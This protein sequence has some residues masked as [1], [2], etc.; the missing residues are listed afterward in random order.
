MIYFICIGYL[1]GSMPSGYL[2][3][4]WFAGIDIRAKGSGSTGATNVLREVGKAA[5]IGVLIVD[6]AKGAIAVLIAKAFNL[7]ETSEVL[8]GLAALS[9]HIW[10]IWL[11]FKGGKAVATSLGML[12][13]LSLPVGLACL[14]IFL[15]TISFTKIVSLS[16]IFTS[17]CLPWLMAWSLDGTTKPAYLI[18]ACATTIMVL[19]RHRSNIKRLIAGTEPRIS[20][21][22]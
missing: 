6:I 12:L 22:R 11:K 9:G 8:V 10:P 17:I 3:G 13:G 15:A 18:V 14:G 20:Q 1:L 19:W 16:S 4:Q 2:A 21:F 7:S 5:A